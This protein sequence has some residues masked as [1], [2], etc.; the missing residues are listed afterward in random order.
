MCTTCPLPIHYI[1]KEVYAAL[2][3]LP[4]DACGRGRRRHSLPPHAAACPGRPPPGIHRRGGRDRCP[5]G[6]DRRRRGR[7]TRQHHGVHDVRHVG[8]LGLDGDRPAAHGLLFFPMDGT[9]AGRHRSR[10][11]RRGTLHLGRYGRAY[12][13]P[14]DPH[15]GLLRTPPGRAG[16]VPHRPDHRHAPGHRRAS[17]SGAAATW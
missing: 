15:G 17:R 1:K 3:N 11:R 8:V 4:A 7:R 5:A 16:R 9:A 2:D 12:D 6:R 10:G 14:R 13:H